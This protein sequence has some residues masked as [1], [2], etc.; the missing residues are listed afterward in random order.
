MAQP[1]FPH[2]SLVLRRKG[3]YRHPIGRFPRQTEREAANVANY[4]SHASTLTHSVDQIRAIWAKDGETESA[5]ATIIESGKPLLLEI[6]PRFDLEDV[7]RLL[8]FEVVS[9]EE[10]GFVIVATEDLDLRRVREVIEKFGK[11]ESGGGAAAKIYE[12]SESSGQSRLEHIVS[13]SLQQRWGQ[14]ADDE[15]VWIVAGISCNAGVAPRIT[16][17]RKNETEAQYRERQR[18]ETFEA[19]EKWDDTR[20][21]RLRHL[22]EFASN[23]RGF[24]SESTSDSVGEIPEEFSVQMRLPGIGLRDFVFNY[25]YLFEVNEVDQAQLPISPLPTSA[26][27]A[28][29]VVVTAPG[30]DDA[31]VCIIDSGIQENHRLLRASIDAANSKC[32]F[33]PDPTDVADHVKPSGHGTRVAGV[34]LFGDS[35]PTTGTYQ[36]PFWLQ[37]ARILTDQDGLPVDKAVFDMIAEIVDHF[38]NGPRQTRLFNQSVNA[39]ASCRLKHMSAWAAIMDALSHRQDV[40]FIQSAGNVMMQAHAAIRLGVKEHIAAGRAYPTYLLEKS[41]RIANPGQ[42]LQALT[43]GSISADVFRSPN[44]KSFAD[45]PLRPSAFSRT[46]KGI[47]DAIKPDV[48]EIGGDYLY[49]PSNDIS[50]N[51]AG[52]HLYPDLIRATM[53]AAGPPSDR[54][55]SGT[56]FAAPKVTRLAA[57]LSTQFPKSSTLLYRA[58]IAQSAR[59]PE[60]VMKA[61]AVEQAKA[62]R[63]LGYGIPDAKKATENTDYR[64]TMITRD[65]VRLRAKHADAYQ[66][67]IPSALRK[68]GAT[69][70][71]MI[72]VCLSYSA[73][74]RRTRRDRRGYLS[75]WLDWHTNHTDEDAK[76]FLDRVLKTDESPYKPESERFEWVVGERENYG[77][78]TGPN[79]SAGT[80][81]K[82]WCVLPGDQLPESFCVAVVGHKGHSVDPFDEAKYHLAVT[83]D[84]LGQEVE[85]YHDMQ[86]E[87]EKLEALVEVEQ[88]EVTVDEAEV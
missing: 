44:W 68:A 82:D 37:N 30:S 88:A 20:N 28:T 51:P 78:L 8:N 56:S 11:Q 12:I 35:V 76:S 19:Y 70:Q 58:L 34:V 5:T 55:T 50:C 73:S 66:I 9:E 14:I 36:A 61:S 4:A 72:E 64:V 2:L 31:T 75:T 17:P 79:R 23:Y 16:A 57:Q 69:G 7:R 87:L 3:Q 42:S 38:R 47:F 84:V 13:K 86:I 60:W 83:V 62:I 33:G 41:C 77:N 59:L 15:D 53:H 43:V 1:D 45:A 25:P 46:G 65:A 48:V 80:L 18:D 21:E 24:V 32:F 85:I 27:V 74:V 81:Q 67:N 40:L 39:H 26:S 10:D 52:R 29:P 54:D 63:H 49:S 6:D 22:Q 71:V